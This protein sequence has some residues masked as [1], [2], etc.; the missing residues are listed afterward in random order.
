[1]TGY[2]CSVFL[3][4]L[5]HLSLS[6]PYSFVFQADIYPC[7]SV[8]GLIYNDFVLFHTLLLPP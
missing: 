5:C 3:K 1:M 2:N 4:Q 6:Q 7:L 8:I